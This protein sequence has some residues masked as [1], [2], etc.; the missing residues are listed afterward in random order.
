M[1]TITVNVSDEAE[2]NFRQT[3]E[4]EL[5]EGKG[6]LGRAIEEAITEWAAEK[7]QRKLR[8][9]ALALLKK[10]GLYKVGKNYTFKRE[11]A[12]EDRYRKITGTN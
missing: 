9:E 10:G 12:Y 6:K 5:G 8:E 4:A 1:G 2:Q 3:V 11:E 7:K